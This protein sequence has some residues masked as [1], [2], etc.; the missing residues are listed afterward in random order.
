MVDYSLILSYLFKTL[1]T[2]I[3]EIRNDF[4]KIGTS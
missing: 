1:V 4:L 2:V 3:K